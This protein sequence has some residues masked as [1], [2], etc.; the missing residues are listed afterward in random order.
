MSAMYEDVHIQ[1]KQKA[2]IL[3]DLN[4]LT[5]THFSRTHIARFSC[6]LG[7]GGGVCLGGCVPRGGV[8]CLPGGCLSGGCT[9]PPLH[10]GIH[11]PVN[12]MTDRQA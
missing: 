12:R 4:R 5:R 7:G 1:W 10:A 9:P 8:G 6:R 3:F 2:I 11:P